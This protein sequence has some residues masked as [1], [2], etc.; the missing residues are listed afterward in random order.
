MTA[1]P[2]ARQAA[3]SLPFFLHSIKAA[4]TA[5]QVTAMCLEAAMRAAVTGGGGGGESSPAMVFLFFLAGLL[6]AVLVYVG[7]GRG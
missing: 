6:A 2:A 4:E 7:V 5:A 1:S 3:G